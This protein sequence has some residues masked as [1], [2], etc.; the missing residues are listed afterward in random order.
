M[1]NRRALFV[2]GFLLFLALPLA[3]QEQPGPVARLF[4]VKPKAGMRAQ[5]EQAAKR[6]MEWHRQQKDTWTYYGWESVTGEQIGTY[7]FGTF[8]H[9]WKDFDARAKFDEADSADYYANVAQYVE[10]RSSVFD[11][12]HPEISR[13]LEGESPL[14]QVIV[15]QVKVGEQ[16]EF[17]QGI[18]KAHEAIKKT[19]W[20]VH[21]DWYELANGG[22]G[23]A[24]V[25]VLP[26]KNW[27]DFEPPE[28]SFPAMLEKAFGRQ[29]AES[30]LKMFNYNTRKQTSEIS[31]SRPDLS[32][33]PAAK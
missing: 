25:L 15:F 2:L 6:H 4:F 11:I 20:P 26:H 18:R 1:L 28:L 23:P 19:D 29:E 14:V 12:Y 16:E 22:E 13:P 3:A 30:V 9:H 17:L 8:G 21:Y 10:S 31:K 32:Y 5:F 27:A 33:I 24:Y 7:G